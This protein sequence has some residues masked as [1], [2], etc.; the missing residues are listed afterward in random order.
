MAMILL[1][2]M[3]NPVRYLHQEKLFEQLQREAI[4]KERFELDG[5]KLFSQEEFKLMVCGDQ[6]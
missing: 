3:L 2:K 4:G 5:N 1:K 6:R